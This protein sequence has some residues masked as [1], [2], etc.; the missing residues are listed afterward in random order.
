MVLEH[1]KHQLME[2]T[3]EIREDIYKGIIQKIDQ[4]GGFVISSPAE[5]MMHMLKKLQ[6]KVRLPPRAFQGVNKIISILGRS[7]DIF[8][9]HVKRDLQRRSMIG[10]NGNGND[11]K[12]WILDLVNNDEDGSVN[13]RPS[14]ATGGRSLEQGN[15][16]LTP[17]PIS[18]EQK[19]RDRLLEK[20]DHWNFDVFEAEALTKGH[21]LLLL[22]ITIFQRYN[23]IQKFNIDPIKLRNFVSQIEAG[24]INN[25]YHN[26]VHASDVVRTTHYFLKVAGIKDYMKDHEMLAAIVAA[27]IHDFEHPGVSN[28]FL[29][30]TKHEYAILYNDTSV[31]ENHHLAA[32]F[33][34]LQKSEC[35]IFENLKP[36]QKRSVRKN[37]INLVL[38]TDLANHFGEIGR[39][40]TSVASE[41]VD[42][43]DGDTRLMILR[44]A[45]KCADLG[46]VAKSFDQHRRWTGRITEEM[47]LQGDTEK[48][49]GM[50]PSPIMDRDANKNIAKSQ[51]GFIK[52]LVEPMYKEF[53][54]FLEKDDRLLKLPCLKQLKSNLAYWEGEAKN[55]KSKKDKEIKI[56]SM[57]EGKH[58]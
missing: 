1:E 31:L 42:K 13:P 23:F 35:D 14:S 37:I 34:I 43:K 10:G 54:C 30:A 26:S 52:F 39:F 58:Q 17:N 40:S 16:S 24:Y 46:H 29:V 12:A 51:L 21:G 50:K 9:P 48:K 20:L 6:E 4:S 53:I 8:K 45:I 41:N 27:V 19:A 33:R 3:N 2:G 22:T 25:P 38:A 32:A 57:K 28:N 56:H 44:I 49:I 11:I 15:A 7:N 5:T 55:M 47:Y 36:E 18:S